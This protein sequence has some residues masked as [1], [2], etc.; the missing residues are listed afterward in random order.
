MIFKN[1]YGNRIRNQTLNGNGNNNPVD[2]GSLIQYLNTP[3]GSYNLYG[4][5]ALNEIVTYTCI[6][7]LSE[8]LGKLPCKLYR[9]SIKDGKETTQSIDHYL[10]SLLKL[11]PNP[12]MS[13]S[14]F[15]K[16]LEVLRNVYGNS[17]AWIDFI[18]S[19]RDIGKIQG[20]YPL[21]PEKMAIWVDDVGLISSK[22][23]LW[24]IYTDNAGRQH[25]LQSSDLFHFK[26]LTTDGIVGIAPIE[27][28]KD[29]IENAKSSQKFLN[30]SYKNGMQT[31][32]LINYVGEL[33]DVAKETFR[34]KF[35]S[36]SNG[37][38]NVGRVSLLPIGYQFTP[39]EM[40]MVDAQFLETSKLT[41]QQIS[42]AYGC[43]LHQ[44]NELVKSS[45]STTSEANREF[46]TDTMMA[47]LTMYEQ[48]ITYKAFTNSELNN[49]YYAKFNADVM[50]R[51]DAT[52]RYDSYA[53]A[54][55]NGFK[56]P[57]ECRAL[58]EDPPL[59]GGDRLLL[60]GNYIPAEMAG[61]QY[62][63]KGGNG[64]A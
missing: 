35:E 49:N 29:S 3:A 13:A 54:V 47:I 17:Y 11:R 36:M 34:T 56:T 63:K 33:N 32:G 15:W 28:L 22:N 10:G 27:I 50:L 21:D 19:G 23:S 24:Y 8:T 46:Y 1:S 6:K 12:Y 57:N 9:K 18:Q 51:G 61:M 39:I 26:S 52:A 44:I 37:L 30:G 53:K 59:P 14:D 58:E 25:K 43:K 38:N 16:C 60:N 48:E 41:A 64:N 42:A 5:N 7:I 20:F 4:K 2:I 55:Q 31:K 40:K 62:E 45:Y